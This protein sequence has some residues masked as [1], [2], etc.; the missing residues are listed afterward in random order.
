[1]ELNERIKNLRLLK[2][3]TQKELG[4][5]VGVSETSIKCWESGTK[6]PSMQ[7]IISLSTAF[8]VSTDYLLGVTS[9]TPNDD[10]TLD[11]LLNKSEK[12]L[13]SNYRMLDKYGKTI[14]ETVCELEKRRT[15]ESQPITETIP[16]KDKTPY[17]HTRQIPRYI[18]PIAAGYSVPIDEDEFE[19]IEI[20]SSVLPDADFAVEISGNSMFP[21]VEDGDIVFVKRTN[22]I[23]IG[24]VGV[25]CV[26]GAMYCKQ[27]HIDNSG[28]LTLVSA[29][30]ELRNSNVRLTA[31]SGS[32]VICYGKVLLEKKI[33]FPKYF[34]AQCKEMHP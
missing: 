14:V 33:P 24:D 32:S 9:Y 23:E 1:M 25:F 28:N 19:M 27:Y 11:L 16:T 15:T 3:F 34:I 6:K 21:Y 29:N 22:D 5:I 8:E 20:D 26:D 2:L 4:K 10:V 31:D 30:P 7:K 12:L 18:T 17:C 13:I